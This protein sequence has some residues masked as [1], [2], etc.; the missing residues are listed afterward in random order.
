MPEEASPSPPPPST[1]DL[2]AWAPIRR[3]VF[4]MLWST[5]L[6]ANIC[7]WMNDVAAAWMM[8]SM[9]TS[10][11]WVALVQTASTL[12][13]FL[14]GLPSGALADILDRRRYFIMTQF[15]VAGVA[16]LLCI[17]VIADV[18]TP[19]LLLALT[20]ANGVGL[21]MRW[22]VFSAI[23]PEL[24]P[25]VQL[26]AALA[27]NGVSMNASRIVGPLVAGALIAGAGTE[28]VFVLNAV[29]S[30]IS[31]FVIMR[32]RRDHAPSPLGRER[33]VSA[34]RVGL[35]YVGQSARLRAVLLRISIFFF[36]S[37]ALLAML[38][39]VARGL[40][41]GGGDAGTFT[42]L[43]ASMGAGAIVAA[44]NL[45]RLR[46]MMP[47]DVLVM[48]ATLLQSASMA[49]MAFAPN[50]YVAVPAMVLNGMAWIT[51][52]NSLSVSAQLALPD[53]V[54]ARGM[55]MYQMAIM[56]ASA[57]GA[58]IWGHAATLTSV[59]TGLLMAAASGA[60]VM[61][62][63]QYVVSDLSIEEDLTPSRE[64]KAPVTDAPPGA[65]RVV[66]MIHYQIDP[67]R[68]D[69]FRAVMQ[70]SR[71]SRLRQGALE[72]ELLRDVNKPGHYIEQIIDE[73]WTEHLRRFDRVTASDVSLRERKLGFHLGEEPPLVTRSV[74]EAPGRS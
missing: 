8:T 38:P 51:C 66:V 54:R 23:V 63:A 33:L 7:M 26:P 45:P 46:Q 6:V 2:A 14:L 29:L 64:F 18:M 61:L 25:R 28:Y 3:P 24:V 65:G 16:T 1:A 60:V 57:A 49:V 56:G 67:A 47:R 70:E 31:G 20:F 72:W 71:R 13:V 10:P 41:G 36:H 58:A 22:P 32:W 15:W 48:R 12:P 19:A 42:L 11:L 62:V 37:T 35:Q 55:S 9:T 59:P 52:A 5:W 44:L 69:G 68:A 34:M 30:V 40:H 53:W 73:S 50:V 27:L 4:R 74:V 21:A 39:L 17:A 43:L